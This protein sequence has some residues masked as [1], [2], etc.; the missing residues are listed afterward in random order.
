MFYPF[1]V[2]LI[3]GRFVR[4]VNRFVCEV[5]IK[6]YSSNDNSNNKTLCHVP[7]SGRMKELLTEGAEVMVQ[8]APLNSSRK[9]AFDLYLVKYKGKW[10]SLD[11]RLP[12]KIFEKAVLNNYIP[13]LEEA[14]LLRREPKYKSG[15]FDLEFGLRKEGQK[16]DYKALVECKSVTLVKENTALFPDA[17][18]S[19]GKR[20]LDEL[21]EAVDEGYMSFVVFLVQR[22]DAKEFSPN[23]EMDP[24]FSKSLVK[25]DEKGAEILAYFVK[26]T[27]EGIKWGDSLPVKL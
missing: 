9:T 27:P 11:S 19:R 21:A 22:D 5:A 2:K 8:P 17:P 4:R 7:N 10:V 18:T 12:N 23:W 26:V 25:L 13:P 15:K 6:D 14:K 3:K 24:E 1:D 20:H 16:G